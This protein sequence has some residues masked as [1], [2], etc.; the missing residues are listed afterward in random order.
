MGSK[1]KENVNVNS[2]THFLTSSIPSG[3]LR[4]VANSRATVNSAVASVRTSGVY[5]TRIPLIQINSKVILAPQIRYFIS[6]NHNYLCFSNMRQSVWHIYSSYVKQWMEFYNLL[7][8]KVQY[9]TLKNVDEIIFT[10]VSTFFGICDISE[11]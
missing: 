4:A 6:V 8:I 7:S 10:A 9:L 5:P 11:F 3:N 2:S 1:V